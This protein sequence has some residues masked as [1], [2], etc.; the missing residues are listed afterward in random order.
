MRLTKTKDHGGGLTRLVDLREGG[1]RRHVEGGL[2]G[3]PEGSVSADV[4]HGEVGERVLRLWLPT[5]AFGLGRLGRCGGG[6]DAAG[7][8]CRS[9]RRGSAHRPGRF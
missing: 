8:T 3:H 9:R 2:V 6:A 7:A 1:E 4:V 5:R